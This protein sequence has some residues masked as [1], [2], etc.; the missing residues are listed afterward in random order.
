MSITLDKGQDRPYSTGIEVPYG[1]WL[2]LLQGGTV[3]VDGRRLTLDDA[4]FFPVFPE[5]EVVERG[6]PGSGHH[7]HKGRPGKVGGS[8]P[9]DEHVD[10]H[11]AYP[12]KR[13]HDLLSVPNS[14]RWDDIR[15]AIDLINNVHVMDHRMNPL[16][17][18]ESKARQSGGKY[19]WM[20]RT[21][22]PLDLFVVLGQAEE[23]TLISTVH[24]IGHWIDH[25][26]LGEENVF[27]S[28]DLGGRR[29]RIPE[30]E[31]LIQRIRASETFQELREWKTGQVFTWIDEE[32]IERKG[33]Y[34]LDTKLHQ[35]DDREN[36]V[37]AYVQWIATKNND[38]QLWRGI[39]IAMDEAEEHG[40]P[41]FWSQAEFEPIS[42][43]MDD[44]FRSGGWLRD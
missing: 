2:E 41:L 21:N 12:S 40:P 38:P 20:Q 31:E 9:G 32:G 13:I 29:E 6:G 10:L 1:A 4:P 37:R 15:H 14:E 36:F 24:E 22:E 27:E 3:E 19:R 42:E 11:P 39:Q 28:N 23:W 26:M 7:G 43:A 5:T 35:M 16:P 44:L 25:V 8:Q 17:L 18:K 34:R 30:M 33:R